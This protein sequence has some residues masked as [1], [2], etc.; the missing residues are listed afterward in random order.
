MKCLYCYERLTK[1]STVYCSNQC[2]AD[3]RYYQYIDKWKQG[4]V[5]GARGINTKNISRH[6]RRYLIEKYA[7]SC[8]LCSWNAVN[9]VTGLCPL[10]I[11]HVDGNHENNSESNLRL[12]CPNCHS[13]TANFRNLNRGKG[14]NWR[15]MRYIRVTP[16]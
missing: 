12:I 2:Q 7:N 11:D 10:E 13:L 4:L 14:R 15:R 9:P 5:S 6:I 3:H 8:A 16:P 1:A